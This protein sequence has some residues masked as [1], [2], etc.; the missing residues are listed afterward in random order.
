LDRLRPPLTIGKQ[1]NLARLVRTRMGDAVLER[2]VA[3]L[4]FGRFGVAPERVDVSIAAPGLGPALTRTGSLGGAVADVLVDRRPSSYESL[5]GGL[6]AIVDALIDRLEA[7]GATLHAGVRVDSISRDADGRWLAG[8][9]AEADAPA[10][11]PADALFVATDDVSAR[12]LLAPHLSAAID[13]A[14]TDAAPRRE[15]VTLVL[16]APALDAAPRGVEVY[17]V[18]GALRASGLVHQTARWE[19]LA[20]AAGK[21]R[22]VVSVAFDAQDGAAAT[23]GLAPADVVTLGRAAASA[24]L[25][26]DIDEESVRAVHHR[27]F[28]LSAPESAFGVRERSNA[29]RA[30]VR[31]HAGLAS[32]GAWLSG[33]GLE[34]VVTDARD[35]AERVRRT[36]LFGASKGN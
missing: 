4:T 34:R 31:A 18:P 16:D 10:V 23:D 8:L 13:G 28:A 29:V 21:A 5:E 9:D 1:L 36:A 33:S 11:A 25:G 19:W 32:V 14:M 27:S 3:P 24:L 30:A 20:R 26:V 22:H 2:M 12:A 15:I 7:L 17:A 35:E 6:G